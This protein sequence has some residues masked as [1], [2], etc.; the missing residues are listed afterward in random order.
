MP[1]DVFI[2]LRATIAGL[3]AL[4]MERRENA[5]LAA[6][7][8][9]HVKGFAARIDRARCE[10]HI[11]VEGHLR[12]FRA[13]LGHLVV[14]HKVETV[15]L[16]H[17]KRPKRRFGIALTSHRRRLLATGR[18]VASRDWAETIW[19]SVE[20]GNTWVRLRAVRLPAYYAQHW[21]GLDE[22]TSSVQTDTTDVSLR[23][24]TARAFKSWLD[25]H[26]RDLFPDPV[27]VR[28]TWE[29]TC[30]ELLRACQQQRDYRE[31]DAGAFETWSFSA[32]PT[33]AYL[34]IEADGATF[35]ASGDT[36]MLEPIEKPR[37]KLAGN[38]L[39]VVSG[40][41]NRSFPLPV[42][43]IAT[44]QALRRRGVVRMG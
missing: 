17:E 44:L 31:S 23:N 10:I 12:P 26:Q 27:A 16:A 33:I 21:A 15:T 25:H 1:L 34:V 19:T 14:E 32:Q 3:I 22:G 11:F 7:E 28:A 29:Q 37:F 30:A 6:T 13:P 18:Y 38:K 4:V 8:H 40:E 9:F 20:T 39:T 35:W 5:A 43:R 24:A 42:D 2:S 36:P 41:D